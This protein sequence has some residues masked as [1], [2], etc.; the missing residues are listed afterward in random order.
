MPN[1]STVAD[2][3]VW[4]AGIPAGSIA[5]TNARYPNAIVLTIPSARSAANPRESRWPIGRRPS[6]R[7]AQYD[8]ARGPT[9]SAERF[10][11]RPEAVGD[12]L[13]FERVLHRPA[14]EAPTTET[15]DIPNRRRHPLMADEMQEVERLLKKIL[16]ELREINSKLDGGEHNTSS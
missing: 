4:I 3:G 7:S 8:P 6:L 10:A 5:P 9:A 13:P 16:R 11:T 14:A 15:E 12:R 2:N 1:T